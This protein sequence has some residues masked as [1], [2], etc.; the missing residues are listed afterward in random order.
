MDT[1]FHAILVPTDFSP[2]AEHATRVASE[3]SHIYSAP[4]T[5]I[6]VYDPVAYPLP[7]G[8]VMYTPG[9]L[10]LM[11][12]EFEKRLARAKV[13]ARDDGAVQPQTRLLQ[14]L[15]AS[16][17]VRFANDEGYDLIVLGTHGRSGIA[18]ALFGSVATQ[19]ARTAECPVLIVKR[20][21]QTERSI[22]GTATATPPT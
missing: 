10:S 16:A 1:P 5:L 19:V 20:H 12:E 6:H 8:Y 21:E 9:Q 2:D 4:L 11:W 7:E 18:R 22:R 17:I 3:L 15:T 14:G 13:Q